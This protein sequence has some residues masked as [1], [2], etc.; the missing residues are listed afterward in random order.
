[1]TQSEHVIKAK[2]VHISTKKEK[3]QLVLCTSKTHQ[4]G[5]RP[6][7]INITSN[8]VEKTGSYLKR[9]FCPFKLIQKFNIYRGNYQQDDEQF[10]IFR[11]RS[12]FIALKQE[13][14]L[15]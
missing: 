12:P 13:M 4:R 5:M 8:S 10:F 11:D 6:Q 15:N 14:Y 2:D 3:L 7:K 1:M 9:H